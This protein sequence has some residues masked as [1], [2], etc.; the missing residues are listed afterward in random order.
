VTRNRTRKSGS[1]VGSL[2]LWSRA[3]SRVF[4]QDSGFRTQVSGLR[5][6]DSGFRTQVSGLRFQDPRFRTEDTGGNRAVARAHQPGHTEQQAFE[7]RESKFPERSGSPS[8]PSRAAD[9]FG[10]PPT[11]PHPG[12]TPR[13]FTRRALRPANPVYSRDVLGTPAFRA[14]SCKSSSFCLASSTDFC[15]SAI[16]CLYC[17]S[18]VSQ[19]LE[20]RRRFPASE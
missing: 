4:F 14:C 8:P 3:G 2:A 20:S 19:S 9:L 10:E 11:P 7:R 6:Q 5:F 1:E 16:C 13:R 12:K 15:L 17:M 18:W